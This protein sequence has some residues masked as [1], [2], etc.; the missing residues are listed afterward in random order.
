MT[1]ALHSIVLGF[2]VLATSLTA[3]LAKAS[4]NTIQ[5]EWAEFQSNPRSFLE[6]IP[7]KATEGAPS[8]PSRFS[9]QE[10]R[11]RTFVDIKAADRQSNIK[12]SGAFFRELRDLP[13][14]SQPNQPQTRTRVSSFLDLT[15]FS[16]RGLTPVFTLKDVES[17]GLRSGQLEVQPWSGSYWPIYQGGMA[18]RYAS[19]DFESESV[20]WKSSYN[21]IQKSGSLAKVLE[22]ANLDEIDEL[23]PSEKYDLLIG[24]PQTGHADELGFLTPFMWSEG[25]SYRNSKGNVETWMGYCHGWAPAA[26]VDER[27]TKKIETATAT[28]NLNVQFYPDDLK[29][30]STLLWAKGEFSSSFI[31]GRC[32]DKNPKTDPESGRLLDPDCFDIDPGL[33]H[34]IVVNQLGQLKRGLV[35]DATFDY[36]VWNQPLYEYKTTY[37]NPQTGKPSASLKAASVQV[38]QFT[39]DKFKKFRSPDAVDIVGVEMTIRYVAETSATHALTNSKAED[40]VQ[41][42]SY[43]YDVEL[44]KG[45]EIIGGEWYKNAH[46]DFLWVPQAGQRPISSADAQIPDAA[47]WN[48]QD[49]LPKFW[50]DVARQTAAANGEPVSKIV[51]ALL[52]SSAE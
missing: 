47:A 24:L 34:L 44:N 41:T 29:A 36:Q 20:T 25:E 37:F 7:N 49:P 12:R 46:P 45:G 38:T 28:K 21:F 51:E 27:P 11:T 19:G 31:G 23:S 9:R 5:A 35:I 3:G 8:A 33:W 43:L 22:R 2:F 13:A 1:R 50:Q 4:A 40:S 15:E 6:T 48:L 39:K 18:A 52:Q 10:I 16:K 26:L 30:L 32:N 17:L 14:L 42:V